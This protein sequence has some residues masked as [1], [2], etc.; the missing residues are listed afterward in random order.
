MTFDNQTVGMLLFYLVGTL[1]M[2]A[3]GMLYLA[4]KR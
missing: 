3:V 4:S 2:V 1:L